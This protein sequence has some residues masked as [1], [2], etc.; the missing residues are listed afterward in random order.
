MFGLK[1]KVVKCD[2]CCQEIEGNKFDV[3]KN[4]YNQHF[5]DKMPIQD[6]TRRKLSEEDIK[7]IAITNKSKPYFD[8]SQYIELPIPTSLIKVVLPTITKD[9]ANKGKVKRKLMSINKD[10][11]V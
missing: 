2:C 7:E 9:R 11:E 3:C 10:R 6:S 5:L 8:E 4:C 1:S